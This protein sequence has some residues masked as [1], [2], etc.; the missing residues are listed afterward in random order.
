[1]SYQLRIEELSTLRHKVHREKIFS[2]KKTNK[3]IIVS[4]YFQYSSSIRSVCFQYCFSKF[5]VSN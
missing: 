5:S 3:V 4:V 2:G 1:M